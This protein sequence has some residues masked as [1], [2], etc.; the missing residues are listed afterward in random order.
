MVFVI[1][2]ASGFSVGVGVFFCA[3][4]VLEN[5][6]NSIAVETTAA[7]AA[8]SLAFELQEC[9]NAPTYLTIENWCIIPPY[10]NG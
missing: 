8:D 10:I 5:A 6:D 4:R 3:K 9:Q 2:E 1:G 7:S